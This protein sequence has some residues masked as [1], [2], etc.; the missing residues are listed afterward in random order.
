MLPAPSY[1]VLPGFPNAP[2]TPGPPGISPPTLLPANMTVTPPSGDFSSALPRPTIQTPHVLPNTH[3][4][5][6]GYAPYPSISPVSTSLQGAWL[7]PTQVSG[8]LRPP[9]S[10]YPAA[11]TGPFPLP[12]RSTPIPSAPSPDPQPPGVINVGVSSGNPILSPAPAS[13]STTSTLQLEIPHGIG[14]LR[15]Q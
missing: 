15:A 12:A 1:Q 14:M 13:Q 4:Q 9:L 6:P 8:L 2:V 5:H 11:F 10:P 7:Q 3:L